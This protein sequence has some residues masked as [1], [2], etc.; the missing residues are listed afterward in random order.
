MPEAPHARAPL[1]LFMS[2]S[3]YMPP[4]EPYQET[5]K[6]RS[7]EAT[8]QA[9]AS[10]QSV[11]NYLQEAA[12]NHARLLGLSIEQLVEEN[13][14]WVLGRLRVRLDR[15]PSWREA[16]EVETWPSGEDGLMATRDFLLR[17]DGREFGRATSAWYMLDIGRR[18]PVRIP[19]VVRALELPDREPTLPHTFPRLRM[20]DAYEHEVDFRVRYSD[21]DMN[22]HVNN[23]RYIEWALEGIPGGA[24]A[25]YRLHELD[26][27]FKAETVEGQ[28]V[29]VETAA[30]D[31]QPP[32]RQFR[33]RLSTRD[34]ARE[35]A[36]LSTT[37]VPS[38]S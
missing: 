23:V 2:F 5:F 11:C 13:L 25:D 4:V 18:R 31:S 28:T 3:V 1:D 14:T 38:P 30:V 29:V 33:H 27:Q 24:T 35:V 8:P 17:V 32:E 9:E 22:Q 15:M 7:Y 21:L 19:A 10:V 34:S 16:V 6:I 12:G 37:W 36:L 26:V 20:P